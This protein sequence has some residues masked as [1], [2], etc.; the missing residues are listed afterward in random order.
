[1][2]ALPTLGGDNGVA[3]EINRRGQVAGFTENA[4]QD[5]TCVSPQVLQ[6]V[7]VIW[8]NGKIE[9]RLPPFPGDTAGFAQAINDSGHVTGSTGLCYPSRAVLWKD[10]TVIDL[11]S[12]GGSTNNFSFDINN[13]DQVVGDSDLA[14][15]TVQHAF[16][17]TKK[18]GM[19][20]L[21]TLPDDTWSSTESINN[22]GQVVGVSYVPN[23]SSSAFLWQNG[24]MTDL[25]TL[26]CPGSIF[27]ANALG[28]SDEGQIIGDTVTPDGQVHAYLATPTD[29]GCHGE[30]ASPA[31]QAGTSVSPRI[32][33]LENVRNL[34]RQRLGRRYI[35]TGRT[36]WTSG[37]D[38]EAELGPPE[39]CTT[40]NGLSKEAFHGV[41]SCQ[42]NFGTDTMT[43]ECLEGA[44]C[45]GGQSKAQCPPGEKG[46][47]PIL[48][49]CFNGHSVLLDA[50]SHCKF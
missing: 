12:L 41:G 2:N 5:A 7:A 28:I 48:V 8:R 23:V 9:R 13:R 18:N 1:M 46:K 15:D 21:G 47:D 19:Q 36:H 32:S 27:L 10:G 26:T 33:M 24:V 11:G 22:K 14:G 49:H 20:D 16:L 25:N 44:R 29:D 30:A 42:L 34:L 3:V 39:S 31:E 35:M 17:W 45:I 4:T 6:V 50:K 37:S 40:G 43:G 38:G